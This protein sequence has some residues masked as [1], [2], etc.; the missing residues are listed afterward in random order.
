MAMARSTCAR[1]RDICLRPDEAVV[2]FWWPGKPTDAEW[3]A[4]EAA[5]IREVAVRMH[6]D[7][8]HP[9]DWPS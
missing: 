9:Q 7:L 4:R 6:A 8:G 5:A 2:V 1:C 3:V